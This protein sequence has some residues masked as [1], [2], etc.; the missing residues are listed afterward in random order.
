MES[1]RDKENRGVLRPF[2]K[3]FSTKLKFCPLIL[4]SREE[5]N[6]GK[7]DR[8]TRISIYTDV[9]KLDKRVGSGIFSAK[10]DTRIV[11]RLLDY[12][13]VFQAEIIAIKDIFL[14]LTKSVL[15]TRNV[16]YTDGQAALNSLKSL[17]VSSKILNKGYLVDL[18]VD[19][20]FYFTINV[21]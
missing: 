11:F 14:V 15:T 7:M 20:T 12:C 3:F 5:W 13:S 2:S 4:P 21:Q 19:L 6:R 17:R 8:D 1:S 9:Y 10:L 18:L 16:L